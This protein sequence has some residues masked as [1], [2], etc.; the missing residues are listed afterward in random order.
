[1]LVTGDM[2]GKTERS[3]LEKAVIPGLDVLV[4]GHHGSKYSTDPMF[5]EKLQPETGIISVGDN[6]YGHPAVETLRRMNENNVEVYRT[7]QNGTV[8]MRVY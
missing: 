6:S 7:D 8:T 2:D 3:L 1:M 5:L 4:V